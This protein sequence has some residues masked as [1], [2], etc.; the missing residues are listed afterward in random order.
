MSLDALAKRILGVTM[1]KSWRIRCSDWEA[2][3]LNKRQIEYAMNDALVA[4]HMFLRLVKSKAE[5]RKIVRT[6]YNSISCFPEDKNG[7][8]TEN[9]FLYSEDG[10]DNEVNSDVHDSTVKVSEDNFNNSIHISGCLLAEGQEP[11]IH[12]YSNFH[13]GVTEDRNIGSKS[14]DHESFDDNVNNSQGSFSGKGIDPRICG[15]VVQDFLKRTD[16]ESDY[17]GVTANLNKLELEHAKGYLSREEVIHLLQDPLFFQRAS[18]LCQGVVD[19]G[20]KEIKRKALTKDN[21]KTKECCS[22]MTNIKPYKRGTVRKS[23][24][25]MNCMLAA[26]DGS[27]LCTLDR[28]KAD[29]YIEKGIGEFGQRWQLFYILWCGSIILSLVHILFSCVLGYGNV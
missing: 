29:W 24:L 3:Y 23:P 17:C 7:L 8:G 9:N 2:E 13:S 16:F 26:P 12:K 25:Y 6:A 18:S 5:E 19:L 1:D 20:F 10:S 15:N 14:N 28:K 4:S 22:E 21:G 27:R 11:D